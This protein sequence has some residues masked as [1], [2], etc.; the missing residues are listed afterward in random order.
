MD[1]PCPH[2]DQPRL[3]VDAYTGRGGQDAT[4]LSW[5]P[6]TITV[7]AEQENRPSESCL[8]REAVGWFQR[9]LPQAQPLLCP[10][11]GTCPPTPSVGW[12]KGQ[13]GSSWARTPQDKR[14][15]GELLNQAA[16]HPVVI[17]KCS[18]QTGI[19]APDRTP[20]AAPHLKA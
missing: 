5:K 18:P 14:N 9:G 10:V 6:A 12:Q 17:Q 2:T 11:Q 15:G 1:C 8:C 7:G 13:G 3:H 4:R 16:P 19:L 20:H